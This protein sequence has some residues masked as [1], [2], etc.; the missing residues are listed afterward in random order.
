MYACDNYNMTHNMHT[1]MCA[2]THS[3]PKGGTKVKSPISL[4]KSYNYNDNDFNMYRDYFSTVYV[5]NTLFPLLR[6]ML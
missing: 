2:P 6:E 5:N 4:L 3:Y 1:Q